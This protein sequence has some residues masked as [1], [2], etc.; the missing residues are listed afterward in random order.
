[1][2]SGSTK[3]EPWIGRFPPNGRKGDSLMESIQRDG[4]W[5]HQQA[6]GTWLR[7]DVSSGQWQPSAVGPPPPAPPAIPVKNVP[8]RS[9]SLSVPEMNRP[10]MIAGAAALA[11]LLVVVG[12]LAFS[13][14]TGTPAPAQALAAEQS[15]EPAPKLSKR[16]QF[17]H[18]ADAICVRVMKGLGKLP[19]P[20]N[21]EEA[22]T[23]MKMAREVLQDARRRGLQ[24][25]VPRDARAGWAH[26]IGTP[27][28]MAELDDVIIALE[29]G[30]IAAFEAWLVKNGRYGVRDMRWASRYGM[31]VCSQELS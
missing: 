26:M 11:I 17:T 31:A 9:R 23:Y 7:Y 10:M 5:W 12:A 13:G 15:T 24:L 18:D 8:T 22:V 30:D 16:Q 4:T 20:T 14:G 19:V 29:S 28:Y 2:A 25:D 21:L 1:M 3:E 6:D 27:K